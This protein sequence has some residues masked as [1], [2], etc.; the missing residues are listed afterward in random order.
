MYIYIA[1]SR[2]HLYCARYVNIHQR[3]MF[4]VNV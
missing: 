3:E 2:E 1:Q 4:S